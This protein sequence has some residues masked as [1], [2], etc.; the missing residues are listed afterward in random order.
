MQQQWNNGTMEGLLGQCNRTINC[1]AG[2]ECFLQYQCPVLVIPPRWRLQTIVS[3]DSVRGHFMPLQCLRPVG[4]KLGAMP[5]PQ[6]AR[7]LLP[8]SHG[9]IL[10][11]I[12]FQGLK[13]KFGLFEFF[14][15]SSH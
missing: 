9:R 13:L 11:K 5:P 12:I 7:G 10:K 15:F 14:E 6:G 1:I 4:P 2:G 3:G 8:G